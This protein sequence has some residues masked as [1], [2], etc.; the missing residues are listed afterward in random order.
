MRLWLAIAF[1]LIT[2]EVAWW[3]NSLYAGTPLFAV[4][5]EEVYAWLAV[6]LLAITLCIG[7]VY[8]LFPAA[9]A[10][11]LMR[12]AR[13]LLGVGTAWF[14][15][16][17]AVIVYVGPFGFPNPLHLLPAFRWSLLLGVVALAILLAMAFTSF[18][19]AFRG[20]GIWWFR[21]HRLVYTAGVLIIVHS[22]LIGS[23]ARKPS[24]YWWLIITSGVLVLVQL[25]AWQEKRRPK[26]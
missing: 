1:G 11:L 9:P 25:A 14:A 8:R 23:H 26:P 17:H 2:L 22:I 20:M 19:K 7:P 21:L 12:D 15:T 18:D 5:L 4:R 6:G 16:L 10:K 13:R 24:V 3:A